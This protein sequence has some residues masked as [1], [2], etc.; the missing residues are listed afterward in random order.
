M[1][2]GVLDAQQWAM[3]LAATE[4]WG[5]VVLI[6]VYSVLVAAVLPTPSE[7]ILLVPLM[8]DAPPVLRW[9][10]IILL[11]AT[12]KMLGSVLAVAISRRVPQPSRRGASG[13]F[14]QVLTR[15]I[16]PLV[17]RYG[18]AGLAVALSVPG[19]PDTIPV[20]GFALLGGSYR[21]YAV[22][23]FIGGVGRSLLV[24]AGVGGAL[25]LV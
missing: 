17:D 25:A 11:G 14:Q 6:V 21:A 8:P 5:G 16:T 19:V 2:E 10:V 24:L 20:Y 4:G 23:T 22:A 15:Q 13:R 18:P 9:T 1:I 3:L 12:A 7:L